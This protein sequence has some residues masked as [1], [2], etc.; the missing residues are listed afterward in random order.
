MPSVAF[1]TEPINCGPTAQL[2]IGTPLELFWEGNG[3][4][5]PEYTDS[6]IIYWGDGDS[7]I[8]KPYPDSTN[9]AVWFADTNHMYTSLGTYSICAVGFNSCGT[10]TMCCEIEITPTNI[11]SQFEVLDSNIVCQDSCVYFRET[12]NNYNY[13]NSL[14]NW[15][16]DWN[17]N[18][19]PTQSPD[20]SIPFVYDTIICHTYDEPGSYLVLHQI[21]GDSTIGLPYNSSFNEF[22]TVFV[23]PAPD[24][25]I[26]NCQPICNLDTL[27]IENNSTINDSIEGM[28]HLAISIGAHQWYIN[29]IPYNS[30]WN[31]LEFTPTVPGI[32]SIKL[33]VW[34][35][36]G[37]SSIDECQVVVYDLPQ[38][39]FFVLPDTICLGD[40]TVF[41][42]DSDQGDWPINT[43]IW[44]FGDNPNNIDTIIN[45]IDATNSYYLS[46]NY[47]V[48]LT[49]IDGVGCS[50]TF[51]NTINISPNINAFFTHDIVCQGNATTF[52]GTGSSSSTDIWRWDFD[53]DGDIDDS[54]SGP[55]VSYTFSNP[56]WH[57]VMLETWNILTTDTCIDLQPESVYVYANPQVEFTADTACFGD[58]TNFINLTENSIDADSM[59]YLWSFYDVISGLDTIIQRTDYEPS[60]EFLDAP[61]G[62]FNVSLTMTDTNLCSDTYTDSILVA[63]P[64]TAIVNDYFK[65][66]LDTIQ[67]LDSSQIGSFSITNWL[68]TISDGEFV[69]GNDSS[70][71]NP[72]VIFDSY[73]SNQIVTLTVTDSI[74]CTD[75]TSAFI[76]IF[77][78]PI[79]NFYADTLL[80]NLCRNEDIRIV[81]NSITP[82]GAS[83]SSYNWSFPGA[84]PNNSNDQIDTILYP[85]AVGNINILLE[86]IDANNCRDIIDSSIYINTPPDAAFT[87]NPICA[88]EH[89]LVNN[90]SWPRLII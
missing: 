46:G 50:D 69:L 10:D 43:W 57:V 62:W 85:A 26:D 49:V 51:E 21:I 23:Y 31:S 60:Y 83:I 73:G 29:N 55:V 4:N 90:Q 82:S 33:E 71:Q 12:S 20:L 64:P 22:D 1:Y 24:V 34:S 17:G 77:Q 9:L 5:N 30:P 53:L 54:L 39:D 11:L 44:S 52:D 7:T 66:D 70:D 47:V 74:G 81:S 35:N 45:Y 88:G 59:S 6:I 41:R 61:G 68:W 67:L 86:I 37:C 89:I 56:G 84:I 8:L 48:G 18:Q 75:N 25:Q 42:D 72:N 27:I 78:N 87:S 76:N 40:T 15:W 28:E 38:S 14:V 63:I 3:Y 36:L 16:F 32:Y 58:I 79:A 13:T 65:C 19:N 80:F 2:P